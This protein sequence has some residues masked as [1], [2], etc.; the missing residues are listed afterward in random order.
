MLISMTIL[1]LSVE[2]VMFLNKKL[3][4]GSFFSNFEITSWFRIV[5]NKIFK[6]FIYFYNSRVKYIYL[7]KI[8][9]DSN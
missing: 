9:V 6:N 5:I 8:F 3:H 4:L 7:K 1:Q 2:K